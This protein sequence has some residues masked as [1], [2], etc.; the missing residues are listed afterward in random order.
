MNRNH[1]ILLALMAAS[2]VAMVGMLV[3]DAS[4]RARA[5]G[6]TFRS[7]GSV[8][9]SGAMVTRTGPHSA[10]VTRGAR[11]ATP[12]GSRSV[13]RSRTVHG[14]PAVGHRR[15][16]RADVRDDVEDAHRRAHVRHAVGHIIRSLP[17]GYTT[18][19]VVGVPYYYYDGV[20]YVKRYE[21][22]ATAYVVSEEPV[23]AVI[24]ELP[25]RYSTV[26]ISG[27]TYYSDGTVYYTRAY[28]SGR[29][30]YVLVHQP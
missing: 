19:Y 22:G 4:A 2:V 13:T 6:S 21:S 29:V 16:H 5:R 18:V 24:Y 17:R 8:R 9:Q 3:P 14:G 7:H 11:V 12:H 10:S 15:A 26:V 1:F 25:P 23:G 27:R 30:S 20:Y 28:Q